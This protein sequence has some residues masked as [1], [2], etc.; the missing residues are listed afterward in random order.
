MGGTGE[1]RPSQYDRES[2]PVHAAT[3]GRCSC[4]ATAST[5]SSVRPHAGIKLNPLSTGALTGD[6]EEKDKKD[7]RSGGEQKQENQSEGQNQFAHGG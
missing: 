4:S 3:S 1:T 7:N 6:T 2:A 5:S